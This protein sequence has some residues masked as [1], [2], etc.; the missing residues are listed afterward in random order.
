MKLRDN[1]FLYAFKDIDLAG[2]E[3]SAYLVRAEKDKE[4]DADKYEKITNKFGVIIFESDVDLSLKDAYL[5]YESRWLLEVMFKQYKSNDA[6]EKTRVQGDFSVIGSEFVNF[7][8][9]VIT[10]RIVNN[11]RA[12]GVLDSMTYG[13]IIE[14]L[15]SVWRE[16]DAKDAPR[17]DD[18]RWTHSIPS[19]IELLEKLGLSSV[20]YTEQ[21]RKEAESKLKEKTD[22]K[23]PRGRPRKEQ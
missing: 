16:S 21:K 7:I 17:S 19:D 10:S 8:S 23:R 1:T 22:Q 11:S 2:S 14:D 15:N 4:F 3:N 20:S 6:L 12:C 18:E 9:S 13:E 5:T